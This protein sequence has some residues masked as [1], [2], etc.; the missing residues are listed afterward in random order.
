M[1]T[2]DGKEPAGREISEIQG[3]P[4]QLGGSG[5]EV[6]AVRGEVGIYLEGQS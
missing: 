2:V 6:R 3:I 4:G 5:E 1:W